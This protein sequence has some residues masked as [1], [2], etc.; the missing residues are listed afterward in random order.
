MA[1]KL[2]MGVATVIVGVALAVGGFL[3]WVV[4]GPVGILARELPRD[5]PPEL[6]VDYRTDVDC[7]L[8]FHVNG[9]TWRLDKQGRTWPP[10]EEWPGI[11]EEF[12][13]WGVPGI[14]RFTS[15]TAAV[16]RART[17]GSE[18]PA[19]TWSGPLADGLC[20]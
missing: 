18:W 16:F 14:V 19:G 5:A 3:L 7:L 10:P 9:E 20:I 1:A 2:L 15:D 13:T 6:N 8:Q 12:S 17:D 11:R 4:G